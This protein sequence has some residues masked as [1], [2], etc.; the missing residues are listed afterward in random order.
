MNIQKIRKAIIADIMDRYN[1][2]P[3]QQDIVDYLENLEQD[4]WGDIY[5]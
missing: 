2:K 4:T 5:Q 3:T 1:N